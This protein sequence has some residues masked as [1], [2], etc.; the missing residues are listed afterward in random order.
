MLAFAADAGAFAAFSVDWTTEELVKSVL[1]RTVPVPFAFGQRYLSYCLHRRIGKDNA[2]WDG[3]MGGSVSGQLLPRH[4][5]NPDWSTALAH[6][7]VRNKVKR[8]ECLVT[9]GFQ[10]TACLPKAPLN[11][12]DYLPYNDQLDVALRQTCYIQKR[13]MREYVT[14]TPFV[15]KH[16]VNFMLALPSE[17]RT[18]QYLYKEIVKEAFPKLFSLPGTTLGGLPVTTS[19]WGHRK[20]TLEKKVVRRM[21]AVK[22]ILPNG[23]ALVAPQSANQAIRGGMVRIAAIRSLFEQNIHDLHARGTIDWLDVRPLWEQHVAGLVQ[24]EPLLNV[25]LALE[26]NLKAADARSESP[27]TD[28]SAVETP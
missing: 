12:V 3:L 16:W 14:R 11:S 15:S 1:A 27:A 25:L 23:E 18:N 6:F 28:V 10:P 19:R 24:N 22:R 5:D 17:H 26:I 7:V 9:P 20:W 4:G 21:P 13:L 8:A 2:F